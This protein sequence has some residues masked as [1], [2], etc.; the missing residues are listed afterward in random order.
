MISSLI[1]ATGSFQEALDKIPELFKIEG[2][3]LP[4]TMKETSLCAGLENGEIVVGKN[5]ISMRVS[6]IKSPV[7]QVFLKD[8]SIKAN[9]KVIDAIKNAEVIIIGPGA[10]YT[11]VISNLVHEDIS[12]AIVASRAKK[13]FISNLM[14][15]PGETDGYT[16]SKHVNEVERYLGKHVLDYAVVNNGKITEEMIKDFNQ[17]DSRPVKIDMENISNR[18][19]CVIK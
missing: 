14:N 19:I 16:L 13:I 9:P 5:N 6:E 7:K 8:S 11:S 10:L 17:I 18:A 2:Q 12:K 1:T 15:S 3:I 4:T